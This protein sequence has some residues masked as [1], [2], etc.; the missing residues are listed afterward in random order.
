MDAT[1]GLCLDVQNNT[2]GQ[3]LILNTCNMNNINQ[4]FNFVPSNPNLLPAGFSTIMNVATKSCICLNLVNNPLAQC[5]CASTSYDGSQYW[6]ISNSPDTNTDNTY[7]ISSIT[8]FQF[9]NAGGSSA[10]YN[11]VYGYTT[12]SGGVMARWYFIP[13][14]NYFQIRNVGTDMCIDSKGISTATMSENTCDTTFTNTNQLYVITPSSSQSPP[15]T[16][17]QIVNA[18]SNKCLQSISNQRVVQNECGNGTDTT[19]WF[20]LK[21]IGSQVYSILAYTGMALDG[22]TQVQSLNANGNSYQ[23][24]Y[25]IPKGAYWYIVNHGTNACIEIPGGVTTDGTQTQGNP[26]NLTDKNQ[27][28]IFVLAK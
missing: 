26:C 20:T 5:S 21:Y 13:Y 24:W 22:G 4:L 19:T 3:N 1:G 17:T 6:T 27:Q 10:T 14:A 11:P 15:T 8:G 7:I 16:W 9:N 25:P 23:Q 18:V 2:V 28:F 12:S